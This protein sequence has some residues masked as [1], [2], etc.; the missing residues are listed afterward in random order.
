MM[1]VL[2]RKDIGGN[3]HVT[4][5]AETGSDTSENQGSPRI[6]DKNQKLEEARKDSSLWLSEET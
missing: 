6:A 1:G 2:I 3:N 4:R 5:E